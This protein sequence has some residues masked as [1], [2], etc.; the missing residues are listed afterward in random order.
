MYIEDVEC[1]GN[2]SFQ[3]HH[4]PP[5][6]LGNADAGPQPYLLSLNIELRSPT[7]TLIDSRLAG[8]RQPYIGC[9][10]RHD[11]AGANVVR[12]DIAVIKNENLDASMAIAFAW[13]KHTEV[14][15]GGS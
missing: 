5:D 15:S 10:W 7:T 12:S 9:D 14:D 11:G 1:I 13:D 4:I 6:N 8:K 2:W 3:E